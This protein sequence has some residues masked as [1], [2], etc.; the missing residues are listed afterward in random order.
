[1]GV[2]SIATAPLF[3]NASSIFDL[4]QRINT[5]C[6]LPIVAVFF[7]GIF[8]VRTNAFAAKLGFLVGAASY[9]GCQVLFAAVPGL[10]P[11]FLHFYAVCFVLSAL[12]MAA[13][14]I[15]MKP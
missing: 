11:Y 4:L 8:T 15:I 10:A 14:T 3:E 1:M 7:V 12:A 2:F 13:S 6:S 9:G 5:M